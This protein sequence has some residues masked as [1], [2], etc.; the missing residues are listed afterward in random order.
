M[1]RS[2]RVTWEKFS[3][4]RDAF[5][6]TLFFIGKFTAARRRGAAVAVCGFMNIRAREIG[7]LSVL[8]VGNDVA[9]P[10]SLV[11][12][13]YGFFLLFRIYGAR[14]AGK[15]MHGNDYCA[16]GLKARCYGLFSR[17]LIV[18]SGVVVIYFS[19]TE[20]HEV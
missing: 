6:N 14:C 13:V 9:S 11:R 16:G 12:I 17:V 19:V 4:R 20:Q 2:A 10:E 3:A 18:S 1:C 7:Y 8:G 5:C 15:F